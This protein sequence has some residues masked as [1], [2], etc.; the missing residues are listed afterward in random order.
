MQDL[1]DLFYFAQ[2]VEKGSFAAAGRALGLPKSRLSRR[3]GALEA[4]LGVR[5]IQRTTRK[6][7][8]TDVGALYYQRC[9]AML[10][11]ADAA[12]TTAE[13]ARSEPMGTLRVSCPV[14]LA[15]LRLAPI[16]PQFL[17]AHPRLY[18]DLI[19]TNRRI[20]L[21]EESVDVALRVRYP[22]EQ[23][24]NLATRR[25]FAVDS[26]TVA[27]PALIAAYAPVLQPE[28]LARLPTI[29][30]IG[31]DKK[32]HWRFRRPD[33][34]ERHM[35][36]PARFSA[37]DFVVLRHAASAGLG[38]THLPSVYCA[39]QLASGELV[40]LLPEW[41]LPLNIAHAVYPSQRGLAPKVRAFLDFLG[42]HLTEPQAVQFRI[43]E[44]A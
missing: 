35:V 44:L 40:R 41:S 34:E 4:Q 10:A 29:G 27:H 26:I 6:L 2:V 16:L 36:L 18:V 23:D 15:E 20:D 19:V 3:V 11:E 14:G 42:E 31:D 5:L 7:A 43:E 1:N 37:D 13:Q 22:G 12:Q 25:L 21:I 28:D 17:A 9:R 24:A 39:E 30:F 38:V 32:L 8:L 33:G